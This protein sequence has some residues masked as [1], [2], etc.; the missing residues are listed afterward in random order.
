MGLLLQVL[1]REYAL[2]RNLDSSVKQCQTWSNLA[3]MNDTLSG[4]VKGFTSLA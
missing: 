3:I 2:F 4:L 1:W